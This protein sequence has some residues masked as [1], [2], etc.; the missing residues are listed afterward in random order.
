MTHRADYLAANR[1]QR[2]PMPGFVLLV[3]DRRDGDPAVRLGITV[4]KKIGGAVIRNRMKRR[5]RA[6]A[7]AAL[8]ALGIP[9][10]DHVLIGREGG[11]ERDYAQLS[12]ELETALKRIAGRREKSTR[13]RRPDQSRG[14]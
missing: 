3:R 5:F 8:P 13:E 10:A 1:G 12:A 11:I 14:Q 2:A 7:K 4:T 9:G 6:L